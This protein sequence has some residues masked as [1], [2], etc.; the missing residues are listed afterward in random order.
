MKSEK[1]IAIVTAIVILLLATA[2]GPFSPISYAQSEQEIDQGAEQE[3]T[4][5]EGSTEQQVVEAAEQEATNATDTEQEIDQ[6]AEQEATD[7]EGSTEQ[8]VV[9]A[10]EQEATN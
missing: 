6:G 2:L 8:Q 1:S 5:V 4:D 10:A 3:A 9:E 7:V